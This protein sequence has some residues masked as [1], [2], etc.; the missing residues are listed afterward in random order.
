VRATLLLL[1]ATALGTAAC[2]G[3][4]P[5]SGQLAERAQRGAQL[6]AR[7]ALDR[8]DYVRAIEHADRA[9]RFRP[10]ARATEA[11]LALIKAEALDGL[12]RP[13]EAALLYRYVA[14]LHGGSD[15]AV[16]AERALEELAARGVDVSPGPAGAPSQPPLTRL[17][18]SRLL[19]VR[20][21]LEAPIEIFYPYRAEAD[22]L[23]GV[24]EVRLHSDG[25]GGL[26]SHE[27]LY[28]SHPLFED[29]VLRALPGFRFVPE[30]MAS[31]E[32]PYT[33]TVRFRF[34]LRG[35]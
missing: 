18:T 21:W 6:R 8:Q 10:P 20:E 33:R 14:S 34:R 17:Q 22:D 32:P 7:E 2:G 3:L 26:A 31:A 4:Q 1:I 27:V 24:V 16:R 9:L 29:A 12:D 28:A 25:R 30:Q 11:K 5:A 35:G 13:S 15:P 19:V 23:E